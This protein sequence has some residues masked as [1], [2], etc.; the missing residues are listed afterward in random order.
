MAVKDEV[1]RFLEGRRGEAL[2]GESIAEQL[3]VS[4]AA[5]WKAVRALRGEGHKIGAASGRGY[6]MEPDSDVLSG[7]G[8]RHYLQENS[9]IREVICL[10]TVD[11][12]N[13]YAKALAEAG[14]AHGTLVVAD[15]QTAG[16]G[17]HGRSFFSPAG[18]GLYMSLILRPSAELER[19]QNV[20]IAAAIAVCRTIEALT[21]LHPRIKW[22]NDIFLRD[23]DGREKK[24]CGILTEA[25]SDVE[26][27]TLQSVIVGIGLNVSTRDFGP[28]L[29]G[30]AGSL[31]PKGVCRNRLGAEI[32]E[33]LMDGQERLGDPE[34]IREYRDRSLLLGR[35]IR[36]LEDGRECRGQALDIDAQGSLVLKKD[37]GETLALRSG[38]VWEVRPTD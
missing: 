10:T 19:F 7:E 17:R 33:R 16:R 36:Y 25:V 15:R 26:S 32:A 9:P 5:V 3:A 28:E 8:I 37:S 14:A 12:T 34:L 11:S 20:T 38:E 31:F 1:L 13:R 4:R 29:S 30:L 24:I 21:E 27:G 23:E 35:N 22:V 6:C 18:T 2:S